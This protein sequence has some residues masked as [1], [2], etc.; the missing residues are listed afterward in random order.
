MTDKKYDD[1]NRGALFKNN[2]KEKDSHP[3]Y[4]GTLNVDGRE[5]YLNGWLRDGKNGKFFSLSVKEK[6][7]RNSDGMDQRVPFDDAMPF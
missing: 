1:T 6:Q 3:D 2:R 4:N 7:P 5:F